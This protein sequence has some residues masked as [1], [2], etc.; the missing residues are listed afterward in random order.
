MCLALALAAQAK[1]LIAEV[2]CEPTDWM[3]EKLERQFGS[4]RVATGLRGPEQLREVW[5]SK[6]G[7]WTMVVTLAIG[8]SCIVVMG[9]DWY[10]QA[11]IDPAR[12]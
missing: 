5:T 11:K 1:S 4:E 7:D 10:T 3:H 9:Q 12:G 2:I 6:S 8:T